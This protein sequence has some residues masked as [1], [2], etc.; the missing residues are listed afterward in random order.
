MGLIT[1]PN[2]VLLLTSITLPD[3]SS[4]EISNPT[5]VLLGCSIVKSLI[6]YYQL[7]SDISQSGG[8]KLFKGKQYKIDRAKAGKRLRATP[9]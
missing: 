7:A 2:T 8:I 1:S 5:I 9:I 4:A 3:S 6:P